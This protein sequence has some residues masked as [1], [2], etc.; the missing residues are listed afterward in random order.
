MN[1]PNGENIAFWVTVALLVIGA[2]ALVASGA[3]KFEKK[4]SA[5]VDLVKTEVVG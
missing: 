5:Y 4:T 1:K 2:W 3:V